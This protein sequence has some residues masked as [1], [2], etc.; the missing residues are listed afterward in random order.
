MNTARSTLIEVPWIVGPAALERHDVVNDVA[1]AGTRGL[2]GRG[3]W[4]WCSKSRLAVSLRLILPWLSRVTPTAARLEEW[5][6]RELA[7]I[8]ECELRARASVRYA[9]ARRLTQ[10]RER[11]RSEEGT[12]HEDAGVARRR[13]GGAPGAAGADR[14]DLRP[15]LERARRRRGGDSGS[16]Q[17]P[18]GARPGAAG[19]M[20]RGKPSRAWCLKCGRP[21]LRRERRPDVTVF[22]HGTKECDPPGPFLLTEAC[23]VKTRPAA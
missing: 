9:T 12:A 10:G 5:L 7:W 3:A 14:G 20:S 16:A 18:R 23:V 4:W 11:E 19:G 17:Q 6:V 1:G 22:H 15:G 21:A 8:E 2:A 13:R